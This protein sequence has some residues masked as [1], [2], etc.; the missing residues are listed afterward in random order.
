MSRILIVEDE[1][2][3]ALGLEDDLKMEGYQVE[4]AS[5]GRSAVARANSFR[6]HLMV[7][8]VMLPDIDGFGVL[9][10]IRANGQPLSVVFLPDRDAP[11]DKINGLTRAGARHGPRPVR[12]WG[13]VRR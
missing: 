5:D 7:L 8:D 13:V 6:P 2:A 12:G 9:K 4:V 3:I 1:P 11:D 10:R